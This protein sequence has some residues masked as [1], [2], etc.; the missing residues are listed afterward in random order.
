MSHT[1]IQFPFDLRKGSQFHKTQ[2]QKHPAFYDTKMLFL[3]GLIL[4]PKERALVLLEKDAKNF[5]NN[6]PFERLVVF[7]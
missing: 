5:Q 7:I 4:K 3:R 1:L 2:V 6:P